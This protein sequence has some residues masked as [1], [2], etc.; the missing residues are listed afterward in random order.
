MSVHSEVKKKSR[1]P[2]ITFLLCLLAALLLWFLGYF[3]K[4]YTVK[5]EYQVY[6]HD[7]PLQKTEY[8]L[9]DSVL[10]LVFKTKGFN[11]F[12]RQYSENNRII[13]IPINQL[14]ESK[15]KNRYN[16][17][18]SKNELSLYLK[19]IGFLGN[20]FVEVEAPETLTVYLK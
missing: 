8:T 7:L 1:K 12:K 13:D 20:E 2:S 10:T 14:I 16:Y 11:Y 5:L 17:M 15:R 19:N 9:S 4:D 6:C 3:S 18:F